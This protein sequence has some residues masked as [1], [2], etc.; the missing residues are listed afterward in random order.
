MD[1]RTRTFYSFL[2]LAASVTTAGCGYNQQTRF[3]MSFLP[4]APH[5]AVADSEILPAPPSVQPN[6]YL[7]QTPSFL[8]AN[9][10]LPARKTHGDAL[11]MRAE[12][13]LLRGKRLYQ[14][15]DIPGA[16]KEFDAAIDLML[17]ASDEN[18]ADRQDFQR[19]LEEMTDSIHHFDLAGMG[20]SATLEPD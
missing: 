14:A 20:A 15:H 16:R 9:P 5:A 18:P 3:Q 12:Q 19:R 17:D 10:P 8:L 7:E 13:T 4:A 2:V 1:D 11:I 6:A